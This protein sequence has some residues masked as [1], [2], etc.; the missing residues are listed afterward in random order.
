VFIWWQIMK[1][2]QYILNECSQFE[3]LFQVDNHVFFFRLSEKIWNSCSYPVWNPPSTL[4]LVSRGL[5]QRVVWYTRVIEL[6][7]TSTSS[8]FSANKCNKTCKC[9][10]FLCTNVMHQCILFSDIH[11]MTLVCFKWFIDA[12]VIKVIFLNQGPLIF[13]I[14]V[15]KKEYYITFIELIF[16]FI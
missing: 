13:S 11:V 7:Y 1:S 2:T 9:H 10:V 4:P 16:I 3:R 6:I 8:V 12:G 5:G 15:Q 14:E